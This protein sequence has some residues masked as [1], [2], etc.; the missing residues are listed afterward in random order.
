MQNELNYEFIIFNIF[1]VLFSYTILHAS[2]GKD[3]KEGII[4][5]GVTE[6]EI[7]VAS[8]CLAR[9]LI[10]PFWKLFGNDFLQKN[11]NHC[12]SC[13]P[14]YLSFLPPNEPSNQTPF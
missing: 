10:L 6:D 14:K 5:N 9:H 7:V 8:R 11:W 13:P 4:G 12:D 1:R 2:D 3:S